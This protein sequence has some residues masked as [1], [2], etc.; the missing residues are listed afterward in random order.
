M[1]R[2]IAL[3]VL[4]PL[5]VAAHAAEPHSCP[6]SLQVRAAIPD[7]AR[8]AEICA[9]AGRAL[10]FL[11]QYG[12]QLRREITFTPVDELVEVNGHAAYASYDSRSDAIRLM[13]Y[14]SIFRH[15]SDPR[16]YDLPFDRSHY[17]GVIA[18]EVAHAVLHQNSSAQRMFAPPQEYLAHATQLAVMPDEAR[19]E[20]IRSKK[21]M[22]WEAGDAVSD[23]YLGADAGKFAV[24]SYLHLTSRS[25]P[26]ALVRQ[27]LKAQGFSFVVPNDA[28]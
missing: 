7:E 16:M 6:A 26:A 22:P 3:L 2:T 13:S 18:H 25:D 10:A 5:S 28:N 23:A 9:A 27:L 19:A 15:A 1:R 4:L 24:K 8:R 14:E 11:G 12:L 17:A 20:L 21:V